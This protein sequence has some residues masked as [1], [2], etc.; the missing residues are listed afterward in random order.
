M[1]SNDLENDLFDDDVDVKDYLVTHQHKLLLPKKVKLC[2]KISISRMDSLIHGYED[3][4]SND[5]P[6]F[7]NNDDIR[8][9]LLKFR[10]NLHSLLDEDINLI[11]RI[12]KHA[13]T[14]RSFLF[15]FFAVYMALESTNFLNNL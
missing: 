8:I 11:S 6:N 15:G 1:N 7:K 9:H 2:F 3:L 5:D 14:P 10:V 13:H 12:K 4:N